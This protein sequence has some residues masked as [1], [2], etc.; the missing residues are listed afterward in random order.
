MK[1]KILFKITKWLIRKYFSH[2]LKMIEGSSNW[3]GKPIAWEWTFID[4]KY[5]KYRNRK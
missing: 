1:Y 5:E 2:S 3:K 4:E